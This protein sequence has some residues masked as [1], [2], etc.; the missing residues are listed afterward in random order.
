MSA[1]V[2]HARKNPSRLDLETSVASA[3]P[4]RLVLMLYDGAIKSMSSARAALLQGNP[5]ARGEALTKAIAMIDEGL[6][7]ALDLQAGEDMA[8]NLTALHDYVRNRLQYANIKGDVAS[9]DEAL[10]LMTELRGAWRD[11]EAKGKAQSTAAPQPGPTDASPQ[12]SG[13]V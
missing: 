11:L 9:I 8:A 13:E 12:S 2:G 6:R 10:R 1:L 5:G 7:P 4:A 3:S